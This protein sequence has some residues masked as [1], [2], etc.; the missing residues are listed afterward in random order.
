MDTNVQYVG[1][2]GGN[3]GKY[4]DDGVHTGVREITLVY[5]TC[6]ESIHVTYDNNGKSF[7][8]V[9]HG[10][11]GGTK[12]AQIKLHF[13]EEVL[14]GVSG[15]YCQVVRGGFPV[16]RSLS[17]KS[18]R[19]TFGPFGVEE[20]TPFNFSAN[21]GKH[22]VGLYGRSGWVLDSIGFFLS[23]P[24]PKQ[25]Q[26]IQMWFEG[27]NLRAV[28]DDE[29]KKTKGSKGKG[30]SWGDTN[31]Q[32]VGPWGGNVG[33][34]FEDGVHTGIREIT[35]VYTTCIDSIR[36]TYDNDGKSLCAVKHGGMGGTKSAQIKLHFPKEI[37]IGVSGHYCPLVHG[38]F[39][40]IRSLSFK[41]NRRTFGPFGVEE[42]TPFNFST[43]GREH[44]V[45]IYGRSGW[46]LGS[47]GFFLSNPKPKLFQRIKMTFK[48]FNLHHAVKD[49]ERKKIKGSKGL[50]FQQFLRLIMD[51]SILL[52]PWGGN[53]GDEWDDGAHSGVREIT[54][55]HGSCIDSIQVTYDN[56]GKLFLEEKHGGIGGNEICSDEILIGVSGHYCPVVYGGS[57]VIRSLTFK[58]NKRTF[59]PFGVEEG[60]PFNFLANGGHIVGLFGRSGWFLDSL[61]FCLSDLKPSLFQ[62]FQIRIKRV[63][64]LAIKDGEHN[65]TKSSK[66]YR[67]F[68]FQQFLRLV[69]DKSILLRP[70]GGNGGDEWDDGVHG[71]VREITLVH[72]GCINS[73]QVT[74][75]NHGK[76]FLEEKHGGIG[77]TKYAQIKLQFPDEILIGV[78]GH[79]CPLFYGGSPVIRSLT[80]KT[81]RR[82][83]GP[84]GVEEGTPFNFFANGGHIVGFVGRSGWFLDSLGFCLS[85]LKPS[86]F[87]R[88]QIMCKG[89]NPLSI[90]E[91]KSS[92]GYTYRR[93]I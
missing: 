41:S 82:T 81:N 43:N 23:N 42:G 22:I 71:G 76:P 72:G 29:R 32:Y 54:L 21:G 19:R 50:Y 17:F 15:H 80:F 62:R 70:W 91:G 13:P 52:R 14:I 45:G 35:L 1:P 83:F 88:F 25:F 56:H 7:R 84:F 36:V 69:M 67:G 10:G 47:I 74:Y 57:P 11:M 89:V 38:G 63:N 37:L 64:P 12:S 87:Q 40:V 48:G 49:D 79:Y 9:K 58:S 34:Y 16:I 33:N 85:N 39:P 90:K 55:L 60:T 24:K 5:T 51:K 27:S 61:G 2:W 20:G 6:I 77:G 75:D 86:L 30:Y 26:R 65:K 53:G 31:V 93:G 68:Y 66:G 3:V 28:K 73:I 8:G 92:K 78:S 18:N 4:W 46:V 44:I 59:G